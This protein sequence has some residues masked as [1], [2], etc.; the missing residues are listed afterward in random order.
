MT[1]STLMMCLMLCR[2]ILGLTV[3]RAWKVSWEILA[4]R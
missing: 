3:V 1:D 4:Y 2:V